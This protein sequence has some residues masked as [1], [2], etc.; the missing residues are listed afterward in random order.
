MK[1]NLLDDCEDVALADDG[2]FLAGNLDLGAVV[3]AGQDL[4]SDLDVHLNVLTIHIAAGADCDDLGNLGLLLGG[5]GQDQAALG[6]FF[7]FDQLNDNAVCK[8]FDFH[9][10]SSSL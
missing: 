7:F 10:G 3:L 5:A 1:S 6:G 2:A 4:I 8:R 9:S